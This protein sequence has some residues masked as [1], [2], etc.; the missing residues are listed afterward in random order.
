MEDGIVAQPAAA[1]ALAAAVLQLRRAGAMR[2]IP[3]VVWAAYP[4]LA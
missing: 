1:Q 3:L 2:V 4:H